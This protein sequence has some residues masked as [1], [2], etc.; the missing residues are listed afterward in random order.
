ML[1]ETIEG[2][3]SPDS[4]WYRS[5]DYYAETTVSGQFHDYDDR[6][7]LRPQDKLLSW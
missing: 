5:V 6:R 2:Y 1:V 4:S 7:R 3:A